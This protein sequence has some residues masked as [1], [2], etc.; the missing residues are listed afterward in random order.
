MSSQALHI[1]LK[2]PS[3]EISTFIFEAGALLYLIVEINRFVQRET[4]FKT[5]HDRFISHLSI[6]G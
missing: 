4:A 1:I 3:L 5:E 6:L 2:T